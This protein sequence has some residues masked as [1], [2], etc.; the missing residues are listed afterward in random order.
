[1]VKLTSAN[2]KVPKSS[3]EFRIVK[4]RCRATRNSLTLTELP[5]ISTINIILNNVKL[6]G[7]FHTA[8]GISTANSPRSIMTGEIL[9]Y[10]I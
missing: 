9:N 3:K 1:M 4:E 6:L 8:A 10:Q 2:K 7:Y 5:V